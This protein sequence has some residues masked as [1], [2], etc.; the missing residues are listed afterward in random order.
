[1]QEQ[2]G[3]FRSISAFRNY[4]R[5]KMSPEVSL[6]RIVA[7]IKRA[8]GTLEKGQLASEM[9][10]DVEAVNEALVPL[11][12]DGVVTVEPGPDR[13]SEKDVVRL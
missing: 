8:G 1:M 6:T 13:E 2:H 9:G 4:K 7:L 12:R 10:V 5:G 3:K 11:L